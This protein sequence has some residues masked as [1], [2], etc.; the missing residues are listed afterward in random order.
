MHEQM[1]YL[2]QFENK[3]KFGLGKDSLNPS[4]EPGIEKKGQREDPLQLAND[5]DLVRSFNGQLNEE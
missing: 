2:E 5:F 4:F 3:H 1:R